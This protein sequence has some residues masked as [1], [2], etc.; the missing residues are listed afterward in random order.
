MFD[1]DKIFNETVQERK[2]F[3][4]EDDLKFAFAWK[5]KEFDNNINIILEKPQKI[6]Y[7]N[8]ENNDVPSHSSIDILLE[9]DELFCPI[10]LK[11]IT[12]TQ[13]STPEYR[14]RFRRD[15]YRIEQ[16]LINKNRNN[17]GFA[18]FLTNKLIIKKQTNCK[19]FDFNY[20]IDNKISQE[21]K[22]WNYETRK[23]VTQ[24]YFIEPNWM[25]THSTKHWTCKGDNFIQLNLRQ[26]YDIKWK[27]IKI[28]DE[29]SYY[30]CIVEV[31]G[32][33]Q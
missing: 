1:I 17:V 31:K 9:T 16:L 19:S 28:D 33:L 5:I 15:I 14:F 23:T 26:D 32:Y 29:L 2:H 18:I 10:E 3:H 11:F 6:T 27:E 12:K 8:R 24:K 21:D 7:K 30:Y 22:G 25:N 20:G 4:S 13:N